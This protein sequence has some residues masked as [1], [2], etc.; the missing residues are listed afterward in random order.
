M[1]ADWIAVGERPKLYFNSRTITISSKGT[2]KVW[3][4]Q[5]ADK[6]MI[7]KVKDMSLE[8]RRSKKAPLRNVEDWG[9][10]MTLAE[11]DCK[12]R[13]SRPLE[14]QQY[15]KEGKP[16]DYYPCD[17]SMMGI[18]PGSLMEVLFEAVCR[19]K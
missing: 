11:F 2:L 1:G 7:D 13:T 18:A 3:L 10:T 15:D 14:I 9:S 4:L 19:Y 5:P 16:M 8:E 17:Y 12:E 6:E